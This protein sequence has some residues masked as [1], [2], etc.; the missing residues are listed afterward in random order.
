M[1]NIYNLPKE[2]YNQYIAEPVQKTIQSIQE[3]PHKSALKF[4]KI[5]LAIGE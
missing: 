2:F 4:A 3:D 5:G 1:A